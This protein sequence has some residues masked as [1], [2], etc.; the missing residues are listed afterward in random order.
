MGVRGGYIG[1]GMGVGCW[2]DP[3]QNLLLFRQNGIYEI[4][5]TLPF[6]AMCSIPQ[7][8][9]NPYTIDTIHGT[10]L[11]TAHAHPKNCVQPVFG[12]EIM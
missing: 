5:T 10:G 4:Y 8:I 3:N 7:L 6:A 9:I 11:E 1:V 12:G 2:G